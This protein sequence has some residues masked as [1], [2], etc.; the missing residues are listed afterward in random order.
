M[1]DQFKGNDYTCLC[2]EDSQGLV[3]PHTPGNEMLL[4][5]ST[6]CPSSPFIQVLQFLKTSE[7]YLRA[8]IKTK[9]MHF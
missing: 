4:K 7:R 5:C 6:T 3:A 9:C 1:E 8:L 2:V